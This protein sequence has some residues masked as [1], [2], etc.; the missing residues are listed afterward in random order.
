MLK[1]P[2][3]ADRTV[4]VVSLLEDRPDTLKKIADAYAKLEASK[5]KYNDE[6]RERTA[7]L[8]NLKKLSVK[9]PGN[10]VQE[11]S[12]PI[13]TIDHIIL[14]EE[15]MLRRADESLNG[16]D[17]R[18]AYELVLRVENRFPTWELSTP[19]FE[20]LVRLKSFLRDTLGGG[21]FRSRMIKLESAASAN[22]TNATSTDRTEQP[23]SESSNSDP[24]QLRIFSLKN[25]NAND[26]AKIIQSLFGFPTKV[27]TDE[28]TN[29]LIVSSDEHSLSEI[30][31]IL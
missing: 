14:F 2:T 5:P 22:Q 27:A 17:I 13:S 1:A 26:A 21:D 20:N 8:E 18:T 15:L 3:E 29:S 25:S 10:S 23:N 9:L 16:G 11:I 19:R 31:A 12:L 4:I 6:R 7:R 24:E 28:R 30:E